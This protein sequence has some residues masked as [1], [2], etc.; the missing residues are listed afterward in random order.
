MGGDVKTKLIN[1]KLISVI[2]DPN[3]NWNWYFGKILNKDFN[4]IDN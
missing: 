1:N 2:K 3:L 4:I